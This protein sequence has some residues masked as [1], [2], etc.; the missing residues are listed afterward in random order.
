MPRPF[1]FTATVCYYKPACKSKPRLEW[2]V[3]YLTN[4]TFLKCGLYVTLFLSFSK[5]RRKCSDQTCSSFCSFHPS[6]LNLDTLYIRYGSVYIVEF[7]QLKTLIWKIR[8]GIPAYVFNYNIHI[9]FSMP[10]HLA[11]SKKKRKRHYPNLQ[12][13]NPKW[14]KI[15]IKVTE[16]N[17]SNNNVL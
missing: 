9:F 14:K 3:F 1:P 12:N 4:A 7:Q 2:V 10:N 17:K 8:N 11:L 5:R 13:K 6:S 15:T 16:R